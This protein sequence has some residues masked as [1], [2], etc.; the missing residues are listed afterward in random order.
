MIQITPQKNQ[1]AAALQK[2]EKLGALKY[3]ICNGEG[4]VYG[5]LGQIEQLI[6]TK[7]IK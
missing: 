2:S 4:N 6:N 7:R 3:S 1:I 5:F